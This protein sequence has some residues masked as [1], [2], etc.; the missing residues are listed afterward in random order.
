MLFLAHLSKVLTDENCTDAYNR[1]MYDT[2]FNNLA[3]VLLAATVDEFEQISYTGEYSGTNSVIANIVSDGK[4]ESFEYDSLFAALMKEYGVS[5]KLNSAYWRYV[6]IEAAG[7]YISYSMSAL[8]SLELFVKG[9][10][11]FE[12]AKQSYFKLFTFTDNEEFA[13]ID[14]FG[15]LVVTAGYAETLEYAGLYS[16]FQEELYTSLKNYFDSL[17]ESK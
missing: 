8:P 13:E 10:E 4:V 14:E 6:A 16:P 2:V 12:S 5:G 9:V 7:Y 11:D 3:I 17:E 1:V 15:D